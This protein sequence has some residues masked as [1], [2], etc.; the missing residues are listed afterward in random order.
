MATTKASEASTSATNAA[1]SATSASNSAS[2]ATTKASEASTSATNAANS[3][4]QAAGYVTEITNS[5]ASAVKGK[6][7][8]VLD[9]RLEDIEKDID[10][11]TVDTKTGTSI[12]STVADDYVAE[13]TKIEGAYIATKP[14]ESADVSPGNVAIITFPNNFVITSTN[15]DSS[16]SN[17]YTVANEI[18]K[19]PNGVYDTIE[20][21]ADGKWYHVRNVGKIV[22]NGAETWIKATRGV[23]SG[24]R[25][26]TTVSDKKIDNSGNSLLCDKLK[27]I[28]YNPGLASIT[29]VSYVVSGHSSANTIN[30]A[31]SE[32]D[33]MTV[34][35]FKA[36]LSSNPITVY[37]ELT[38]TVSI[39]IND[40]K[41]TSY[42]GVTNVSSNANPQ[43]T[44]T[45]T[46][47]SRLAN[48][49]S[50]MDTKKANA[51]QEAI[52]TP[53]FTNSWVT[54][55]TAVGY[56]KNSIGKVEFVGSIK[57]GVL[58]SSAFT[59]PVGYRPS[60]TIRRACVSNGAFGY[61]EI[62]T[63]GTVKPYGNNT[64][65]EIGA[66]SF[67]VDA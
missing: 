28:D 33:S 51:T 36:W 66:I 22:L 55:S 56:Y 19:L 18:R 65:I 9:D 37:Y 48:A 32:F 17:T 24:S 8:T 23:T 4:S 11:A 38:D 64:Y 1:N 5:H 53:T 44:I 62:G 46:F 67:R 35:Q 45:A 10:T 29:T 14:N 58:G 50:V 52:I 2:T 54:N 16:K 39:L 43:V 49:Y 3:A 6:T 57:N 30:I 61:L 27:R 60:Q 12:Q 26:Y 25:F 40:V 21:K 42:N 63:D 31:S 59:L 7:F 47:K 20:K 41:L 13:I 15:S 34:T